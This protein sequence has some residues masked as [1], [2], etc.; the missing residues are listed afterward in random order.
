MK[1]VRNYGGSPL[2]RFDRQTNQYVFDIGTAEVSFDDAAKIYG[3]DA[4]IS[5]LLLAKGPK[6]PTM[7]NENFSEEK[8]QP[9]QDINKQVALL[10][11]L[12]LGCKKHPS[13]RAIRKATG[14]C[15]DCVVV[16]NARQE[17]QNFYVG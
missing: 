7:G 14:K 10:E 13:Y 15:D 16:W 5:A 4:A 6:Q 2:C 11:V 12:A 17:L 3:K 8:A 1:N 9:S